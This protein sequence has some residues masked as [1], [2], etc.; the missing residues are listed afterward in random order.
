MFF[1][2]VRIDNL[3][4]FHLSFL[5]LVESGQN[6]VNI[7]EKKTTKKFITGTSKS[8]ENKDVCQNIV[9]KQYVWVHSISMLTSWRMIFL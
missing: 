6:L 7:K 1:F 9:E 2:Q 4:S 8:N 5:Q 3:L